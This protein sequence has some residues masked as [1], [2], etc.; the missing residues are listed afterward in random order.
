MKVVTN[1]K[2]PAALKILISAKIAE[3]T[4]QLENIPV[5]GNKVNLT[6][7]SSCPKFLLIT[8]FMSRRLHRHY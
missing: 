7:V 6:C 5:E 8:F 1:S 2:N 3:K 4:V